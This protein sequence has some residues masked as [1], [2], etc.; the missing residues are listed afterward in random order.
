MP[1]PEQALALQAQRT[2]GGRWKMMAVLLVCAAPVL[3]SYLTY[4]VIRP[5]GRGNFGTLIEPQRPL[6]DQPGVSLTGQT[7]NLHSLRGQ[8]LLVSV[9]GGACGDDCRR[10][11]YLQRQLRESLGRER[12]RLDWVWLIADDAPVADALL[13]ALREA[14]VLRVP[15]A[16]LSA[17]LLPA[18]GHQLAEHLYLVDP[19][20]N[21]M[22]RFP[23][24][25]DLTTAPRAKRDLV[26]LLRASA[27][28]DPAGREAGP[29][30]AR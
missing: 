7:D 23:A 28:W 6:P 21:W 14:R 25:L 20:G 5:E 11:L 29:V 2:R 9:A 27:P 26:R 18:S 13:P 19:M 4:Y 15:L 10:Q 24:D 16:A 30:A 1:A 17:W 12:D 3:A 22:L 8:W